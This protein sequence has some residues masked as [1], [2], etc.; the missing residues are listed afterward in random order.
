MA[1]LRYLSE[2]YFPRLFLPVIMR[3]SF[4]SPF[5]S[6]YSSSSLPF[7]F[8]PSPLSILICCGLGQ[9]DRYI[10]VISFINL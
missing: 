9:T 3:S 7:Y 4:L 10:L 5:P 8:M 6:S 2:I 1:F